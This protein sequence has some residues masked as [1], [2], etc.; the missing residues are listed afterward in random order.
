MG[1]KWGGRFSLRK[2]QAQEKLS[3]LALS[4]C[5]GYRRSMTW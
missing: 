5:L 2:P 4:K 1:E 3:D